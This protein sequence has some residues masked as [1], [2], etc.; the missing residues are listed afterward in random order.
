MEVEKYTKTKS[1]YYLRCID[2]K[3]KKKYIARG[4][5]PFE[6]HMKIIEKEDEVSISK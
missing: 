3:T 4:K 1:G 5:T 6:V 2:E